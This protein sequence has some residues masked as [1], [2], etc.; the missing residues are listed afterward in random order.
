MKLKQQTP[1]SLH[2]SNIV[3]RRV[4]ILEQLSL[5]TLTLKHLLNSKKNTC[6]LSF[7]DL[8]TPTILQ[9]YCH[10]SPLACVT[11]RSQTSTLPL[12]LAFISSTYTNHNFTTSRLRTF[13]LAFAPP[14]VFVCAKRCISTHT[15]SRTFLPSS[16]RVSMPQFQYLL[17][18]PPLRI[19]SLPASGPPRFRIFDTPRLCVFPHLHLCAS[20]PVRL[21]A[22]AR[23]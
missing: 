6:T 5:N 20:A 12:V 22:T 16:P 15:P 14:P 8:C 9:P 2:I 4:R 3:N 19:N 23:F 10:P 21:G 11:P 13:A 17:T 1:V 7:R 18:P